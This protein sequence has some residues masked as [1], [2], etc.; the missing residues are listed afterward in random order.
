MASISG[1][2]EPR[3]DQQWRV[4]VQ[5]ELARSDNGSTGAEVVYS[6]NGE[7]V[8]KDSRRSLRVN[9]E[10]E[11]VVT[12][13]VVDVRKKNLTYAPQLNGPSSITLVRPEIESD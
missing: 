9:L 10:E 13:S 1:W 3:D 8:T 2:A 4:T 12:I 7:L 5:V 11:D 6:V